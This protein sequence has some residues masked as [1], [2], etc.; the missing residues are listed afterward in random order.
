MFEPTEHTPAQKAVLRQKSTEHA[1][2]IALVAI[3]AVGL[4][5]YGTER[6]MGFFLWWGTIGAAVAFALGYLSRWSNLVDELDREA[7]RE[8]ARNR[9][10]PKPEEPSPS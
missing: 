10:V 3:V 4:F 5:T 9:P 8:T 7:V 1:V 2:G 6:P